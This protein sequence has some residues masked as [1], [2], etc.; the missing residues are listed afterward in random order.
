MIKIGQN[1]KPIQKTTQNRA[2][3][4]FV[5]AWDNKRQG[6]WKCPVKYQIK[7]G[8][9]FEQNLKADKQILQINLEP[10]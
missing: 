10:D 3:R 8:Y 4:V 7:K 5:S 1:H 9:I 2:L 6:H